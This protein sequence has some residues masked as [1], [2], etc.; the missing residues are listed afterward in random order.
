M[1]KRQLRFAPEGQ[2]YQAFDNKIKM[3]INFLPVSICQT[4]M[5]PTENAFKAAHVMENY[6]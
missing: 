3:L 1:V 5:R 2:K 4:I 6:F